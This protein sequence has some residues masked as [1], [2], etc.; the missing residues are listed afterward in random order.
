MNCDYSFVTIEA[1]YAIST[2][3]CEYEF[4]NIN[5]YLLSEGGAILYDEQGNPI[6]VE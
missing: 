5:T 1:E 2:M 4:G 3:E 6:E